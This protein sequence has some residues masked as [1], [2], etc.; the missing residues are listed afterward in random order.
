MARYHDGLVDAPFLVAA[1]EV[2]EDGTLQPV[3]P[4]RCLLAGRGD[5]RW[6]IHSRRQ[7]KTGPCFALAFVRCLTHL[8][9]GTVYP[10]G[11]APYARAPIAPVDLRGELISSPAGALDWSQTVLA[12]AIDAAEGR[13]W[14]KEAP[15]RDVGGRDLE[16]DPARRR[17]S[18]GRHIAFVAGVLGIGSDLDESKRERIAR[19][20]GIPCLILN[21]EATEFREARR[22]SERGRAIRRVVEQLP[23]GR[24]LAGRL[25]EAGVI[26]GLLVRRLLHRDPGGGSRTDSFPGNGLTS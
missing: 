2:S 3:L 26:A 23:R 18:Q 22:Y 17:R 7:R 10:P 8:F 15:V 5:C 20:I 19:T 4:V 1:Y 24:D 12:G 25:V 9:G 21:Q 16:I 6:R 13:L 11:Y 14:P